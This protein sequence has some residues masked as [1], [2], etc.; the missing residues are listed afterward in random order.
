MCLVQNGSVICPVIF[1]R[2]IMIRRSCFCLN[3]LEY[4]DYRELF[5]VAALRFAIGERFIVLHLPMSRCGILDNAEYSLN[6]GHSTVNHQ[7]K[8]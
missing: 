6:L 8:W 3:A 4:I 5:T 2:A 7:L 1:Y